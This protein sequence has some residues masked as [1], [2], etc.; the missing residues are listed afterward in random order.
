MECVKSLK[1]AAQLLEQ[2]L[3]IVDFAI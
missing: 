2:W 3:V 1:N